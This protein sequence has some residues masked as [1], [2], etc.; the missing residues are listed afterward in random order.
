MSP[1]PAE[2]ALHAYHDGEL[3]GLARWRFERRLA[4]SPALRRELQAL[5]L[6]RE[7]VREGE[8]TAPAPDLWEGIAR[9]LPAEPGRGRGWVPAAGW[10]LRPLGAVAVAAAV[11]ALVFVVVSG[12]NAAPGVVR[13][14]DSGDRN[15]VVLEGD[16]DVTIIWVLGG[17]A[18]A[19]PS[20]GGSGEE[21]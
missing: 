13:W 5:A 3:R 2:K 10:W 16:E 17:D 20:E 8:A 21:A 19:P 12:D 15:V 1:S 9:R 6:M 11:A 4:R 14:I 18:A 7:L